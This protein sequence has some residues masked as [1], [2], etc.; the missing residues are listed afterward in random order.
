[1]NSLS[2]LPT[3]L[4]ERLVTLIRLCLEKVKDKEAAKESVEGVPEDRSQHQIQ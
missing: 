4:L 1:M 3:S 2:E